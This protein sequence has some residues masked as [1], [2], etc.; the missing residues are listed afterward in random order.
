VISGR[1]DTTVATIHGGFQAVFGIA[2]NPQANTLYLA[3]GT[4]QTWVISG[5]TDTVTAT[6]GPRG[7]VA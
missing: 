7:L 1:T 3:D 4:D 6:A 2:A 5:R